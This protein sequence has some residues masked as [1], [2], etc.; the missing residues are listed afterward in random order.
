MIYNRSLQDFYTSS[1]EDNDNL[2]PFL[3]G[4]NAFNYLISSLNIKTIILPSYICPMVVDIFKNSGVK[5]F[6]YSNFDSK[7]QVSIN[8]ILSEISKIN[9]P[10][11]TFFLW[12]DYLNL[13]GDIPD[14]LYDILNKKNID[15]IVDATHS[16][17]STNYKCNNVVFGFRKLLNQPFGALLRTEKSQITPLNE[18]SQIKLFK[19]LLVHKLRTNILFLFKAIDNNLVNYLLKRIIIFA[20]FFGFDKNN[21]FLT[22]TYTYNKI[23]DLHK[24]LDY[25]KIGYIRKQNFL[26]YAKYFPKNLNISNLNVSS[27]FGFP[28]FVNNNKILRSHLWSKGVHSFLLWGSLHKDALECNNKELNYLSKS[29]IILPVNQDLTP[30]EITKICDIINGY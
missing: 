23:F 18:I 11:Q 29:I 17:P 14:R 19:F 16:L 22:N 30:N 15:T 13:I 6:F 28:L 8:Q 2:I 26:L 25:Q 21:Y 3:L 7:L 5:I 4:R 24:V 20:D 10:R 27:P 9:N 12:H 1:A